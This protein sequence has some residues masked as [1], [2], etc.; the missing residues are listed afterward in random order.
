M[1]APET[2]L[3]ALNDE[4][5][6]RH[7]WLAIAWNLPD[8][9]TGRSRPRSEAPIRIKAFDCLANPGYLETLNPRLLA[10]LLA[11]PE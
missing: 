7:E 2:I 9:D 3:Y 4:M 6:D 8:T 11:R 5:G 1:F 10:K